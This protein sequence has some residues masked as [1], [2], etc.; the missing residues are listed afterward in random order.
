MDKLEDFKVEAIAD[1]DGF[2]C[3]DI[4]REEWWSVSLTPDDAREFASMLTRCADQAEETGRSL[5]VA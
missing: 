4:A 5:R 3:V 1:A 2:V